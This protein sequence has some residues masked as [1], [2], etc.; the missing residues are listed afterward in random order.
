MLVF[1]QSFVLSV[2]FSR[3][4]KIANTDDLTQISNRHHFMEQAETIFQTSERQDRS[5]GLLFLDIDFFKK[6]NDTYGHDGGDQVLKVF[7]ELVSS[8]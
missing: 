2:R 1:S 5:L 8:G 7:A 3:A 6:V 4:F